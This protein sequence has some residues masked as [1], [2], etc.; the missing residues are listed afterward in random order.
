MLHD[1]DLIFGLLL[2]DRILLGEELVA[3]EIHL[4]LGEQSLIVRQLALVLLFQNLI[5]S[6]IDLRDEIPFV[7]ELAFGISDLGQLTVDLRLYGHRRQRRDGAERVDDFTDIPQRNGRGTDRLQPAWRETASR[8]CRRSHP[9]DGGVE[10][11]R[12]QDREQPNA[13]SKFCT[14]P[15]LYVRPRRRPAKIRCQFI[16]RSA[17][18]LVHNGG[19]SIPKISTYWE[20]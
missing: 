11:E 4:R 20:L 2:G 8:W 14:R 6:L 15:R 16:I 19:S 5:G 10:A 13:N 17:R 12:E 7:D 9:V 18:S 3:R 1:K